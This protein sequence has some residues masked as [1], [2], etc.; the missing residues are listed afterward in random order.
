[1]V[2]IEIRTGAG[3]QES[4]EPCSL[5]VKGVGPAGSRCNIDIG[6]RTFHDVSNICRVFSDLHVFRPP[7]KFS[8]KSCQ[9]CSANRDRHIQCI[10]MRDNMVQGCSVVDGSGSVE[11]AQKDA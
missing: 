8:H 2:C 4:D 3:V 6:A 11:D 10:D 9:A 5:A 1:M 7:F